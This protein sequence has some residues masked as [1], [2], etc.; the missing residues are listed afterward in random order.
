MNI[1][2]DFLDFASNFASAIW[3]LFLLAKVMM[4]FWFYLKI[5]PFLP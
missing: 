1:K 4:S 3:G 5:K 2:V